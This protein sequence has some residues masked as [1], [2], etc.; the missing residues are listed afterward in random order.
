MDAVSGSGLSGGGV[1]SKQACKHGQQ[2]RL[3]RHGGDS[4]KDTDRVIIMG[5]H[6][7]QD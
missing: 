7:T 5:A 4:D 2:Q 6:Y 3:R 1:D